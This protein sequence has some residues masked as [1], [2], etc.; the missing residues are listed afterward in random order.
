MEALA[1][2]S[3]FATLIGFCKDLYET[4]QYYIDAAR[5]DCPNDLKHILIETSSLQ[6]TIESA[7]AKLKAM[8]CRKMNQQRLQSQIDKP[9]QDCQFC[10]KELTKLVPKPMVRDDN[11]KLS[12]TGQAKIL[13]KALAWGTGGKKGTCDM[14]LRNLRAH[15]AI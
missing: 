12:K 9:L 1:I 5:V 8:D 4:Y 13:L 15:K 11:G 14:L 10:I 2:A 3:T 7:E 6:A